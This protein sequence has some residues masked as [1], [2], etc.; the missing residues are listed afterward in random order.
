MHNAS[1]LLAAGGYGS[2]PCG[3]PLSD[4]LSDVL[5]PSAATVVSDARA[6]AAKALPG[7]RR[8]TLRVLPKL[9]KTVAAI[10]YSRRSQSVDH[11]IAP[12]PV[13]GQ[14]SR[15]RPLPSLGTLTGAQNGQELLCAE[16]R[17]P[18]LLGAHTPLAALSASPSRPGVRD[19]TLPSPSG[20]AGDVTSKVRPVHMDRKP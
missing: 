8:A 20:C 12:E 16:Y 11:S 10:T 9:S 14:L 6:G 4:V 19:S 3:S 2:P 7:H 5:S 17:E 15:H 13:Q 18:A 1:L